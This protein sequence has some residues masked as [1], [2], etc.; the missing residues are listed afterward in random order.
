MADQVEITGEALRLLK[1]IET[2]TKAASMLSASAPNKNKADI[3]G[4]RKNNDAI[5]ATAKSFGDTSDSADELADSF[6]DL[7]KSLNGFAKKLGLF[8]TGMKAP[9]ASRVAAKPATIKPKDAADF[10]AFN[11]ASNTLT[12]RVAG[13]TDDFG[14]FSEGLL[15]SVKASYFFGKQ[16]GKLKIPAIAATRQPRIAPTSP[17]LPPKPPKNSTLDLLGDSAGRLNSSFSGLSPRVASL[18]ASFGVLTRLISGPVLDVVSDMFRLQARGISSTDNI[19]DFYINAAKAGMSLQEYTSLLEENR[20]AVSRSSSFEEFNKK[21]ESSTAAL[22]TLG[23]FGAAARQMSATMMSS[24]TALGVPQAQLNGLMQQQISMFERL[25]DTTG[26][27]ADGFSSLLKEVSENENVQSELLGM[28]PQDRAARLLQLTQTRALGESMGLTKEN[29]RA[30]GEALLAQRKELAGDRFKGMGMVRQAGGILGMSASDTEQLARIALKKNKTPEDN[31]RMVALAGQMEASLQAMENSGSVSAENIAEQ[32]RQNM[33]GYMQNILTQS[34]KAKAAAESGDPQKLFNSSVGSFASAVGQFAALVEGITKNPLFTGLKE[35][36]ASIIAVVG[37]LASFKILKGTFGKTQAPTSVSTVGTTAAM[38]TASTLGSKITKVLMAPIQLLTDAANF[39]IAKSGSV[40][41]FMSSFGNGVSSLYDGLKQTPTFLR[42]LTDS[43]RTGLNGGIG[44]LT[45]YASGAGSSFGGLV[46]SAISGINNYSNA[47]KFSAG[48]TSNAATALN[49]SKD[50]AKM[51][52]SGLSSIGSGFMKVFAPQLGFIFGAIEEAFTGQ[53]ATALGMGDGI[54]GRIMGT[55]VA[56]FNG[57]FTGV[58]RLFD[59]ALNWVFEGLGISTRVNTTKYIDYAT[60]M[61]VDGWRLIGATT[62]RAI[63]GLIGSVTEAFGL[64]SP[65]VESLKKAAAEIE[66]AA[67]KNAEA[68]EEMFAK[69][70][71]LRKEGEKQQK[72]LQASTKKTTEEVTKLGVAMPSNVVDGKEALRSS[73]QATVDAAKSRAVV[74]PGQTDR[75]AVNQP[76]VNKKQS[77]AG[78]TDQESS[79]ASSQQMTPMIKLLE[80]QLETAKLILQA[81]NNPALTTTITQPMTLPSRTS[82]ADN[83]GM[84]NTFTG[85]GVTTK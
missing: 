15:R 35:L 60:S 65:W 26:L 11:S 49:V 23:V 80:Q 16:V 34:G 62:M 33:P 12:F 4:S 17:V 38:D 20:V 39:K 3:A 54:F 46:K 52:L 43:I 74:T 50:A 32:L 76:D 8:V 79:P 78:E 2:H 56:G 83:A 68:R 41:G 85:S 10:T 64:K 22:A 58:S 37:A 29:S 59:D 48:I 19:V 45:K 36:G 57:I 31:A 72:A 1:L 25:R 84:M 9:R 51:A 82:F 75:P 7:N 67:A 24:S 73:A 18:A 70:S 42:G 27:T 55:V 6:N 21:L 28:A 40:L 44:T 81:L 47:V 13:I 30:L 53:M 66:A 63:A 77:K 61:I 5:K 14:K 69:D 71:T